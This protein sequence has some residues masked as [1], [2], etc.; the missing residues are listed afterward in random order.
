ML[1]EEILELLNQNPIRAGRL[2]SLFSQ[3][4]AVDIAALFEGLHREKTVQIFRLLPKNM[5]AEVFTYIEADEQQI[6]IEALTDSEVG[7]IVNKLFADDAADLVEEMPSDVVNRIL[8]SASPE[9][10]KTINQLLQYPE[11]SAGS[12]MTT[13]YVELREGTLVKDAFSHIRT[14]GINKETIYTSYVIRPDR[15]LLGFVTAKRLMLADPDN[16]I[17]DI[18]N[19][20]PV[21]AYTTDDQEQVAVRFRKYGLLSMPIVDKDQHLVGIVTVDD[22]VEVIEEE[23]TEDFEKMGA[24]SPSEDPYLKTGVFK[25]AGNRIIWLLFLML[26]ATITGF[27]ISG[28]EDALSVLPVLVAFIPMLMDTGGNAGTQTSTLIIRGM[29]LEEIRF[30]DLPKILWKE[31]R[32]AFICGFT[33]GL[34]NFVRIYV[35]NGRNP[36][37]SLLVT[38]SMLATIV[39]AKTLGCMLPMAAK[40]LKLDPAI[41]AAPLITTIIDGC[42]LAVYFSIARA[43]FG[44]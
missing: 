8:L 25:L 2:R 40:K 11:D 34:V 33:L 41:M 22:V 42:S 10:R 30:R 26:S 27:I 16:R 14:T 29:A 36:L 7:D 6:I 1:K 12:I 5:A 19:A 15:F 13:E 21:F 37:L 20:N 17:S 32:V 35:M 18:M 39:M 3:M 23:N 4:N 24:L 9:K 31:I 28:F 44:L 38:G 43:L